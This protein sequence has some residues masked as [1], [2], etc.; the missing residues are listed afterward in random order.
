[1]DDSEAL[2]ASRMRSLGYSE[3]PFYRGEASGNLPDTYHS[4]YFSRD[5]DYAQGFAQKGGATNPREFRLNLSNT[6]ADHGSVTASRYGA[7]IEAALSN[8]ETKLAENL[9]ESIAPGKGVK[10]VL[11]FSKAQPDFVVAQNGGGALIRQAIENGAANPTSIFTQAGYDAIDSGRD[12][13]KLTGAGI[14]LKNAA[15]NLGRSA[16]RNIHAGYLLPLA[17]GGL[18]YDAASSSAQAAG[19]TPS[20]ARNSGLLAGG[21]AGGATA[22]VGYGLSKFPAIGKFI[23]P[24]GVISNAI[25]DYG[26][27]DTAQLT[28]SLGTTEKD[29]WKDLDAYQDARRRREAMAQGG[30][31]LNDA[32]GR[33]IREAG[34][35]GRNP[36]IPR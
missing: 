24:L 31:S 33:V 6:F 1:M 26:K 5:K 4:A 9:A 20:E 25:S 29:I 13:R 22:G 7:L 21:V 11:G 3:Q 2:R 15:Y 12:V 30:M 16:S 32:I 10:W 36:A 27:E 28:E 17:A 35:V 18:A 14:R 19:A 23:G 34:Q 8:G